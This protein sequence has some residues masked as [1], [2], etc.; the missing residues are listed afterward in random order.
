M[1]IIAKGST[2]WQCFLRRVCRWLL[3]VEF[4]L[5]PLPLPPAAH[6]HR[7]ACRANG[8][9]CTINQA[10][11]NDQRIPNASN[12]GLQT[13]IPHRVVEEEKGNRTLHQLVQQ[14]FVIV[15]PNFVNP[16]RRPKVDFSEVI[17]QQQ[18]I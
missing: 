13:R 14:V 4:V 11:G 8:C 18:Q 17:L 10:P 12:C 16:I 7:N 5:L 1:S 3:L 2:P 6:I 9:I 15:A